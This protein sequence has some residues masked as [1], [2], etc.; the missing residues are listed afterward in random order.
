MPKVLLKDIKVGDVI[1]FTKSC[2][3]KRTAKF[4]VTRSPYISRRFKA[5]S[6]AHR[7]IRVKCLD[8]KFKSVESIQIMGVRNGSFIKFHNKTI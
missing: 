4:E 1:S 6:L 2:S 7:F 8:S 3:L 5:I